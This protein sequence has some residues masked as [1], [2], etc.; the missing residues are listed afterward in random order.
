MSDK[1]KVVV[2]HLL[3]GYQESGQ[4]LDN[5]LRKH[6]KGIPK[7]HIYKIIRSGEI[8]VNGRRKP[9]S[10]SIAPTDKIRLPPFTLVFHQHKKE[11]IKPQTFPIIYEDQ[12]LLVINKPAGVASHG[13][14]G[15]TF[16][17]IE[18]LRRIRPEAYLE[19]IH[20]LDKNTSG[21]LMIAKK[22]SIL[23][24]IHEQL[25]EN[26]PQKIYLALSA[27]P[28][29]EEITSVCLPLK[30][31]RNQDQQKTVYV[32]E[33]GKKAI[34]LFHIVEQ[35]KRH[36]LLKATLKT[37]RTHQIRVHMQSQQAPIAGDERY[38]NFK[39]NKILQR[40]GLKRM[41]LHAYQ[42]SIK[43][44]TNQERL[45]L[46]APLPEDLQHF[47]KQLRVEK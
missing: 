8:R 17:V 3:I 42:L 24:H 34:S 2:N 4:R 1:S 46:E 47:L 14:S 41:F 7:S 28:W 15:I 23:R 43:Y 45:L 5:Y 26:H 12:A 38:G 39:I 35:L 20:R 27:V 9:A 16:G 25:R 30:H 33:N 22:R 18:Q 40:K 6:L 44:P 32:D 36:T 11:P 10:Y 31:F 19:L 29:Q 37:G 21:L 13:G